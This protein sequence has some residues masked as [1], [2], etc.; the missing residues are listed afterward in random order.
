MNIE[1]K[2]SVK[3]VIYKKAI[4]FLNRRINEILD[5]NAN[6]LIWILQHPDTYTA[7]VRSNKKEILDK[8]IKII[9]TNR[10]GKITYHGKGQLICY[11]V[12]DLRKRQKDIRKLISSLENTIILSLKEL[13]IKSFSDR[14]N[15]G[16]W[17]KHNNEIKKVASIG[18]K[19][20]KWIAYHGFSINI[21]TNLKKYNKIIPCGIRN[22]KV[23][24]LNQIKRQNYNKLENIIIKN[25][26]SNLNF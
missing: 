11:F 26:I 18:I 19:I 16:I 23:A 7:G 3:P 22:K 14:N 15:I 10:G 20:K 12:L 17:V 4:G 6:E 24:N 25:F 13:R 9:K 5:N 21:N 2:R 8:K 1:I